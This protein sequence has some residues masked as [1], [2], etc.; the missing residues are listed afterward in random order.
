MKESKSLKIRVACNGADKA[1]VT[2]PI[3]SL[4]IIDTL[5]PENVLGL[6]KKKNIR[7]NE[8]ILRVKETNYEPQTLFKEEIKVDGALK[9]YH[10][11][12]E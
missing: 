1:M 5:M 8:I 11:W 9:S 2:M 7:I 12:I 6:L 4:S 3:F 10:V